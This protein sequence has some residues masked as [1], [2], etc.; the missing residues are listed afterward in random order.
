ML[1]V[2][3]LSFLIVPHSRNP[4]LLPSYFFTSLSLSLSLSFSLCLCLSHPK[5]LSV[6]D[7]HARTHTHT[8]THA[9]AHTRTHTYKH[10]RTHARTHTRTQARARTHAHTHTEIYTHS[11]IVPREGS[12]FC[13]TYLQMCSVSTVSE[14]TSDVEQSRGASAKPS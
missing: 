7:S 11:R 8:R 6:S 10:R 14:K 1:P 5:R 2:I 9:R 4:R 13:S 3:L 12:S